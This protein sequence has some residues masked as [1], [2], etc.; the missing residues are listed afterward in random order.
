MALLK[1][2]GT[3][4]FQLPESLFHQDFPS[5]YCRKIK[6]VAITIPAIVGPYQNIQATLRQ[7]TN[8]VVLK[9]DAEGVKGVAYLL[10][11]EKSS[12]FPDSIRSDWRAQQQIA[13]SKGVNDSG[14]FELN[15]RDERY[16][17]FEGTGAVSHWT[18]EMPKESNRV[19][20]GST[21]GS[22]LDSISDVIIHLRYTAKDG[23]PAFGDKVSAVTASLAAH[24]P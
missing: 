20:P 19:V 5:H 13:I 14:M 4:S 24:A 10:P 11:P 3:C 1:T 16:L 2:T 7:N 9:A 8:R 21:N 18:L 17:P 6:S 22:L 12:D 23:G 15:F